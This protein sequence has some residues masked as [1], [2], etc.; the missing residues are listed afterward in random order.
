MM[1]MVNLASYLT[2]HYINTMTLQSPIIDDD[3]DD[4]VVDV[5][6]DVVDDDDEDSETTPARAGY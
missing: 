6:I 3:D 5:D 2:L 4:V 1:M